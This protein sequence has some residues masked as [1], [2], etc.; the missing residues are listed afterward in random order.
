MGE[1]TGHRVVVLEGRELLDA[2]YRTFLRSLIGV[3][4]RDA[5]LTELV[6]PGRMIGVLDRGKPVGVAG[7]FPGWLVVPGGCRLP[8]AAVTHV[9]VLPTHRRMGIMTAL[10]AEQL[11]DIAAR[12]EVVASLRATEGTIYGR[13]GY[14]IATR[15]ATARLSLRHANVYGPRNLE[16]SISLGDNDND[17]WQTVPALCERAQWVGAV[18]RHRQYWALQRQ[19]WDAGDHTSYTVIHSTN[20]IND[21]FVVYEPINPADWFEAA[22]RSVRVSDF[23]AHTDSAHRGLIAH[24]LDLDGVDIIEF[25][26][27]AVDDPLPLMLTDSR[28]FTVTGVRDETWLRLVDVEA[29]LQ[30]RTY[31]DGPPVVIEVIDEQLPAN[32]GQYRVCAD[33]VARTET[34]ADLSVDV[35][36][37]AQVYLGDA[38]WWQLVMSGRARAQHPGA[39]RKADDL[40][41]TSR[42]PFSGTEF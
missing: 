14:A 19:V 21:G 26:S 29:A 6:E 22:T 1:R 34:S 9:G 33:G 37:L 23:V 13:F 42:L 15:S 12:G 3:V 16:S 20:G 11:T 35:A 32:S 28:A 17:R 8:H 18:S 39:V 7:S 4:P 31:H 24:L 5:D 40:F 2:G 10:I 36:A 41:A 30:G 38:M 25:A 27:R